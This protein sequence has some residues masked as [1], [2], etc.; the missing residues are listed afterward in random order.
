VAP[1]LALL[2]L[3]GCGNLGTLTLRYRAEK[4]LWEAQREEARLKLAAGERPDS[5]SLNQLKERYSSLKKRFPIPP[6]APPGS[7]A[8]LIR[9]DIIRILGDAELSCARLEMMA[10]RPEDAL[11][12][13][14]WVATTAGRDSFLSREAE[15]RAVDALQALGRYDESVAAMWAM[16]DRYPPVPPRTTKEEDPILK[17]PAMITLLHMQLGDSAAARQDRRR[18]MGY[19]ARLLAQRPTPL[20]EAQ[21]RTLAVETQLE[22]GERQGALETLAAFERLI[23]STPELKPRQAEVLYAKGSVQAMPG[24]D[25]RTALATYD[26]VAKQFPES[27]YAARALMESGVLLEREEKLRDALARYRL[28]LEKFPKDPDAGPIALFRSAMLKDRLDDWGG[29][30]QDLEAIPTRFPQSR[31]A[32]EAP[33]AIV[34]HYQRTREGA[35]MKAALLR[36]VEIYRG[37]IARDSTS[38]GNA[39]VRWNIARC[40]AAL[41]RPK[42]AL[43]TIDEMSVKDRRSPLTALAFQQGADLA[44]KTGDPARA[45]AYLERFL[46]YFPSAPDAPKVRAQL[47]RMPAAGR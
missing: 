11:D 7:R 26:Q 19:Y 4:A 5:A 42:D 30:K 37:M 47:A 1:L 18:A 6:Q 25:P 23:A 28:T 15:L 35:A 22:L 14:R 13:A 24:G 20:L 9:V 27:P 12:R 46:L 38:L 45:R 21:V 40:F 33:L 2:A 8:E 29:A 44:A 36:A 34:S 16:V 17:M 39:A 10:R 41:D 32:L 31:G 43:D 3:T